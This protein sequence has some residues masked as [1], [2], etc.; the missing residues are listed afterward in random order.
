MYNT[1]EHDFAVLSVSDQT[2]VNTRSEDNFY[3]YNPATLFCKK[4]GFTIQVEAN[5]WRQ[6]P[7]RGMRAKMGMVDDYA[8]LLNTEASAKAIREAKAD[9]GEEEYFDPVER[10]FKNERHRMV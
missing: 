1:N 9:E 4:C 8:G 3:Y 2:I 6:K 5:V 7:G 10:V